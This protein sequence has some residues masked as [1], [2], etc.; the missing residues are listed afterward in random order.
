MCGAGYAL[1]V[2]VGWPGNPVARAFPNAFAQTGLLPAL[3][4][5]AAVSF[6]IPLLGYQAIATGRA[7]ELVRLS[8]SNQVVYLVTIAVLAAPLGALAVPSA[9]FAYAVTWCVRFRSVSARIYAPRRRQ[10]ELV[11]SGARSDEDP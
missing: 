10:R 3:V 6:L 7:R 5:A 2:G 4:A 1:F 11:A 8:L 9:S